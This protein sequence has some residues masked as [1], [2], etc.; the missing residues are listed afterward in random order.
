MPPSH[1][2]STSHHSSSHSSSHSHSSSRSFS[3]HSS[4]SYRSGSSSVSRHSTTSHRTYAGTPAF[5]RPRRNQ[6]MG[7]PTGNLNTA[8]K[9]FHCKKHDYVYY[10]Q[11]WA[12]ESTGQYFKKGYY[13]EDGN[14]YADVLIKDNQTNEARFVCPYCDTEVRTNWVK[15]AKPSCPNCSAQLQ[16]IEE[17][18]IE[19][20]PY[21]GMTRGSC[22][23]PFSTLRILLFVFLGMSILQSA[24]F[25]LLNFG[26]SD[27]S[28]SSSSISA[29]AQMQSSYYV[30]ELGRSCP[31]DS[32]SGNYYDQTT[33][34][35]FWYNDELDYPAWQYWYEG[36]SSDF[37]EYGWMEYNEFE[38]KWYIEADY[39]DWIELPDTYDTSNLWYIHDYS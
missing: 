10:S 38:G 21:T 33:D 22:R 30:E 17:D 27:V 31:W 1:H 18:E 23:K 8:P 6:P 28:E 12:S 29:P 26:K 14:W 3:S 19:S 7:Y 13:D 25:A 32:E 39:G 37:G 11:S 20:V 2:S 4:S 15:G 16:E 36:I 34:C 35:Y 5:T 9:Q 24:A